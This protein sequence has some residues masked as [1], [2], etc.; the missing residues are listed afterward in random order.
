MRNVTN[1]W[2]IMVLLLCTGFFTVSCSDDEKEVVVPD[3]WVTVSTDL[4]TVGCE[5]GSL[6]RDYTLAEGLDAKVV[7]VVSSE[8][9]CSAYIEKG[10]IMIDVAESDDI[11]GRTAKMFLTYDEK[12]KVELTVEQGKAPVVLA[13]SIDVSAVPETVDIN[14]TL[15][16][17][18]LVNILPVNASYKELNFTIADGSEFIELSEAGIVRGLA[19][20]TAHINVATVDDSGVTAVITLQVAGTI[21]LDRTSW[22]VSTYITYA[23]GLNYVPDNAFVGKPECILDGKTGTALLMVKPGKNM[24]GY[25]APAGENPYFTVDMNEKQTFNFLYWQHRESNGNNNF[26]VLTL[27]IYGSN[28]GTNFTK[29]NEEP[30]ATALNVF[31]E[32]ILDIPES[33]FRYVRIEYLTFSSGGNAAQVVEFGLGLKLGTD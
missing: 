10:K 26:Q 14:E 18:A 27:N 2:T 28:D 31:T 16:L 21:K 23:S 19:V 12:H 6:T 29:I 15:D 8:S 11:N 30:V 9:W 13:E 7:Y 25:Q 5:G 22:T 33:T 17:N 3:N 20:G 32:Q 1:I 24:N 4:M